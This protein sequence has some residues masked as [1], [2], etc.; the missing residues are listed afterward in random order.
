VWFCHPV[1]VQKACPFRLWLCQLIERLIERSLGVP[2]RRMN[3]PSINRYKNHRFPVEIISHAVWLYFRFCLSY[4]DV[5]ELLFERG[6][7][8]TYEAIRKWEHLVG[9]FFDHGAHAGHFCKAQR[10]H[11]IGWHPRRPALDSSSTEEQLK[12]THFDRSFG[13]AH[14]EQCAVHS[15]A[16][17]QCR[18][19]FPAGRGRE[20]DARSAQ[21]LQLRCGI[22]SDAVNI[23]HPRCGKC[24]TLAR[25]SSH[26]PG[27]AP[28]FY[29]PPVR[30]LPPGSLLALLS[31]LPFAV[32]P[33]SSRQL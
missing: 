30:S 21:F 11:R 20:N 12:A 26:V 14:D 29:V 9:L 1:C 31:Y 32:L 10:V 22:G 28:E 27:Q 4:R 3:P 24:H 23:T 33:F 6:V 8:V 5:E 19:R 7:N 18:H 25:K 16:P 17:N 2:I 15:Q 13:R